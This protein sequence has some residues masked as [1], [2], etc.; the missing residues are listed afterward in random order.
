ME[1]D[2]WIHGLKWKDSFPGNLTHLFINTASSC[3]HILGHGA[4]RALLC[5]SQC[6][7]GLQQ[8]S[9]HHHRCQ[10]SDRW[11]P[12]S[13]LGKRQTEGVKSGEQGSFLDGSHRHWQ[14]VHFLR[15]CWLF[16]LPETEIQQTLLTSNFPHSWTVPALSESAVTHLLLP[17]A[18]SSS[19]SPR[20]FTLV[21]FL[22]Q[23][24][25]LNALLCIPLP[26]LIK[27]NL[28]LHK[29]TTQCHHFLSFFLHD[30]SFYADTSDR[31]V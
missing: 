15:Q 14:L 2:E 6:V 20:T 13:F 11:A 17:E 22:M 7:V 9:C 21:N 4:Y 10:N 29:T 16:Q 18:A 1:E 28:H 31:E 19:T 3:S 5:W 27:Y 24:F 12:S 26:P 23:E 8:Q 30:L 25:Y